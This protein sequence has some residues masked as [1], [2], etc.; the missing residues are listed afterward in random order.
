MSVSGYDWLMMMMNLLQIM[1]R[2]QGIQDSLL[3]PV[4]LLHIEMVVFLGYLNDSTA[5]DGLVTI[6]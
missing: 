5:T 6:Q 2:R 1:V 4:N 3:G